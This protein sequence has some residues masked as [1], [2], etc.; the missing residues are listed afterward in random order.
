[1][2][3]RQSCKYHSSYQFV[4]DDENRNFDGGVDDEDA[5]AGGADTPRRHSA[6]TIV[7]SAAAPVRFIAVQTNPDH[8]WCSCAHDVMSNYVALHEHF[9]L[10][11]IDEPN[12]GREN[13]SGGKLRKNEVL[14]SKLMKYEAALQHLDESSLVVLLDC[15]IFIT[16]TKISPVDVWNEFAHEDTSIIVSRDAHWKMNVPINAG[17]II[18]K[19]SK[20]SREILESVREKGRL[21][22]HGNLYNARTLVDQP[23]LTFELSELNQVDTKPEAECEIHSKVTIVSQRV[24]NSF[25]RNPDSFW[26]GFHYDPPESKWRVGD[27]VS[28]VTGMKTKQRVEAAKLFGNGCVGI[29]D[30]TRGIKLT[31]DGVKALS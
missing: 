7:P 1:M 15:D 5:F 29:V 31:S 27:W 8:Y 22:G 26:S 19:P 30:N 23:R 21:T 11:W 28:H 2:P 12:G 9:E 10:H 4:D 16:N 20:F 18:V 17:M 13:K 14:A 24:M 25:Y 3:L 6:S